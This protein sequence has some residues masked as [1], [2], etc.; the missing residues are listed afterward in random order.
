[1]GILDVVRV[2]LLEKKSMLLCVGISA[3]LQSSGLLVCSV[4]NV[5]LVNIL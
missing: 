2:R 4:K 3:T 1:M 5:G